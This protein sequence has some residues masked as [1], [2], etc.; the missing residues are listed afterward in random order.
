MR[1]TRPIRRSIAVAY[2]SDDGVAPGPSW[3]QGKVWRLDAALD[4]IIDSIGTGVWLPWLVLSAAWAVAVVSTVC[5][6]LLLR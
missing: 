5:T 1:N 4:R 6:L 2:P 3:S